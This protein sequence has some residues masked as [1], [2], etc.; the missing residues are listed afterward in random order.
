[1]NAYNG[2]YQKVKPEEYE[3]AADNS[4]HN[5]DYIVCHE[6][7]EFVCDSTFYY[8]HGK[9]GYKDTNQK[10]YLICGCFVVHCHI[11]RDK[12]INP[13]ARIGNVKD[14]S[15]EHILPLHFAG[16]LYVAF[17][18]GYVATSGSIN[19]KTYDYTTTNQSYDTLSVVGAEQRTH[20]KPCNEDHDDVRKRN[21]E[22]KLHSA[23]ET[24]GYA[25]L[26]ERKKCR[27]D[28]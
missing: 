18:L 17:W 7:F 5:G 10:R 8:I 28:H 14:K 12:P 3:Y 9:D 16:G 20:S 15:F 27:T 13:Y 19:S 21:T 22:S 25:C 1:M 26:N 23:S 24:F 6:A 4:V 11:Y 2:A